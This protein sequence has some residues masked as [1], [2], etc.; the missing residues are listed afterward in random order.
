M[1]PKHRILAGILA[2]TAAANLAGYA[3]R[4]TAQSADKPDNAAPAREDD[5]PSVVFDPTLVERL[6]QLQADHRKARDQ[7]LKDP[8]AWDEGR[9][10]RAGLDRAELG[11]LW[12]SLVDSPDA[13]ARLR[14]HA[15]H[16]ARL[17]RMLDLAQA[18]P[19]AA[20]TKRIQ[21][22]LEH[23]LV[24]HAQNMQT[25]RAALRLQ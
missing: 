10:Q 6:A 9:A 23:E 7:A 4:A 1:N 21:A 13:Q 16:M 15:D 14:M 22:A 12:G 17:N 19:D 5:T 8:K 3:S 25:L 11:K 18:S 24:Q 2:L 20:L